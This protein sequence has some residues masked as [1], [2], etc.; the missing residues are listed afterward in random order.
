M[1][2]LS[3]GPLAP[4]A[5]IPKKPLLLVVM[6]GVGIGP[7]DEYNALELANIPTLKKLFAS[8]NRF[9]TVK[10]H[11]KAVGLP[12]DADMGNSEVGHNALGAG[13]IVLQGASLVDQA[14]ESG[15]MYTSDAYKYISQ[16]FA[17]NTLH[18]LGLLSDGGVHSRTDQIFAL[19]RRAAAD[20][21][22]R[23]R[24]HALYDG[25]D[26]PDGTSKL[27]TEQ[28]EAVLAEVRAAHGTDARIASGGGRMYVTMDR[29]EADWSIV[30]RGWKTHV[31]GEARQFAS[32]GEALATFK[33]EDPKVCDQYIPPFVVA[34]DGQ[35]VGTIEDDDAVVFLNYRGD[36][37]IQISQAFEA[38]EGDF[39]KF[40][41]KVVPKVRYAGM[42]R[43]DGDLGIPKNFLVPPPAISKTSGEYLA[44]SGVRVW[45]CSETQKF[46]H[47]TYFWNGNR[48]SKFS[49]TLE[50]YLEIPSDRVVFNEKPVMK[51]VEIAD[52][53]AKALRSGNYDCVRINFPNG[54]MVG[55]TGDLQAC[56]TA[57]EAVD[58][59]LEQLIKVV[60][61]IGGVFLITADH[62]NC[63]DMVQRDK[64]GEPL[65][66]EKGET[67]PLT[68]HTLTPVPVV[69]GGAGLIP[70]AHLRRDATAGLAN[71]TATYI[72]LLGFEAPADYEQTLMVVEKK[73]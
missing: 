71:V 35:P 33:A 14:I 27:F 45:A 38:A 31:L 73:E 57:I 58:Q 36:R 39:T 55:H 18:L 54:D 17:N 13:R 56:I 16:S 37:S 53:A 50:T 6:D 62:G 52:E 51:A 25:R 34:E 12:S 20:G 66:D 21:A 32:A 60:D 72:N 47:V 41:R 48:S 28:L 63:D 1:S 8:G 2:N 64:K 30:E 9:S 61:E 26:V 42:M 69:I 67:I 44:A 65:R 29:Y 10:A 40:E 15:A 59:G 23:I 3:V 46:G 22:K 49:D 5:T 70:E 24:V 11:G 43:Y 7:N 19:L 68:S 4:H